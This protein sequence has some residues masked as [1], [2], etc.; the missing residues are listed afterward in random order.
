MV[1]HEFFELTR[2]EAMSKIFESIGDFYNRQRIYSSLNYQWSGGYEATSCQSFAIFRG[3]F[4][5]EEFENECF[6]TLDNKGF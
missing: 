5:V 6:N 1:P 3:P 2:S 4:L